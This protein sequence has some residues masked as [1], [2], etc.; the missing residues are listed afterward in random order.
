MISFKVTRIGSST[1]VILTTE[2]RQYLG[3]EKGDTLYLTKAPDGGLRLTPYD[4]DFEAT[5][6]SATKIA[7]R[8]R[9]LLR[10]LSK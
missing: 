3:V 2:A 1:G 9:D 8:D 7:H 5:M 6:K 10:A 4:P